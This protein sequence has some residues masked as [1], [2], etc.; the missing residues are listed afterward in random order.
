MTTNSPTTRDTRI[1]VFRALALITIFVNHIPGTPYEHFTHKN[2]GFSDAAEAF[3]LIS[4]MAVGLAYGMK[5][6][7]GNR[8]LMTLKALRR[9]ATLYLTHIVTT[10]ATLAIFSAGAVWFAKPELLVKINIEKFMT[11]TPET[12]IG[13]MTLGHQLGYNNILPLYATLLLMVPLFLLI[14]AWSMRAVS[15]RSADGPRRGEA[16]LLEEIRAVNEDLGRRHHRDAVLPAA[17]ARARDGIGDEV[18]EIESGL[19]DQA[20]ERKEPTALGHLPEPWQVA[21]DEV[22]AGNGLLAVRHDLAPQAV[23]RERAAADAYA[24]DHLEL[25]L[26]PVHRHENRV[27]M[28]EDAEAL[29]QS[30][31][32]FEHRRRRDDA[33]RFR[34]PCPATRPRL[35]AA[36]LR[37]DCGIDEAAGVAGIDLPPPQKLGRGVKREGLA[38][39]RPR[40][41]GDEAGPH[42][43]VD[44]PD[45]RAVGKP[46]GRGERRTRRELAGQMVADQVEDDR[47]LA[48][49]RVEGQR[50]PALGVDLV[51]EV[52]RAQELEAGAAI[53]GR[54]ALLIRPLRRRRAIQIGQ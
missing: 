6:R 54:R 16:G 20:V 31:F 12:M 2:L 11:A 28:D 26:Q 8:L 18:G 4:G 33:R 53:D 34:A 21:G 41:L 32:R 15:T 14:G 23:D 47:Q 1:D 37:S 43:L 52:E 36:V 19:R 40:P 9:T 25:P 46:G 27:G 7:P 48:K 10:L 42:H 49:A 22:V 38:G 39:V 30:E 35:S 5:F 17:I 13:L 50:A 3:V 29:R 45:R 24:E 51:D 44:R